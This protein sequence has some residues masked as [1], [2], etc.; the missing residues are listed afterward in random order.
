[1]TDITTKDEE[2]ATEG[3]GAAREVFTEALRQ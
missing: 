2:A 1:M 3:F